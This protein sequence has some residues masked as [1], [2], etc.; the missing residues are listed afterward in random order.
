ML[1]IVLSEKELIIYVFERSTGTHISWI[2]NLEV[3]QLFKI[4]YVLGFHPDDNESLIVALRSMTVETGTRKIRGSEYFS[5]HVREL[6]DLICS[7]NFDMTCPRFI[8]CCSWSLS[9]R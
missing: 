3:K 1:K 5:G 7:D 8:T 6:P 4:G 2:N 9:S